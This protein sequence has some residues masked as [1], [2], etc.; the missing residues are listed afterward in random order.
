MKKVWQKNPNKPRVGLFKVR[1]GF[2]LMNIFTS[3]VR[4]KN[5]ENN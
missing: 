1:P 2:S 5:L 4:G 3:K